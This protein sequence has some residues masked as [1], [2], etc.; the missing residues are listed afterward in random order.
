MASNNS[1]IKEEISR[2]LTFAHSKKE[3][4][5]SELF[6]VIVEFLE[7]RHTEMAGNELSLMSEILTKLLNDVAMNIREKLAMRLAQDSDAP[8]EL[9]IMLANDQIEVALP[10]LSLSRL[11]SDDSLIEI[12][13]HKTVQHQLAI[14][15][16]RE[17]SASVCR[18][19]VSIGNSKT[20]IMLLNNPRARIDR[21]SF[22]FLVDK[23][24]D[25]P[26]LQPPL[27]E[28]PDL[29]KEMAAKMY[30]WVSDTLKQSILTNF[31]LSEIEID[32]LVTGAV[33][34]ATAEDD[35]LT[36]Q[37]KSEILLV[38]KLHKADR[39]KPSFLMKCLRQGQSSLFEIA[40]AKM[41][42]VPLKIMRSLLYDRDT[43]TIAIVCYAATIDRS[44]FMTIY[45]LSRT[46]RN[47]DPDLTDS[48]I[49]EVLE[50]Y[51]KLDRQDVL[52]TIEKWVAEA[53]RGPLS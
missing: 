51:R 26:P 36:T 6:T 23:S 48:E 33:K 11:L 45:Q 40:F 24:R 9:I 22:S 43:K 35:I 16:R 41:I 44:V 53:T 13:R 3:G 15:S 27:I 2:L 10:V 46:V 14:T 42:Q 50:Y 21:E 30:Q 38:N 4:G 8:V 39:L 20:L 29:P 52:V 5:R 47:L 1:P 18:E 17:L 7:H 37:E 25:N 12:I 49:A 28:R 32:R 19:L 31:H 34:D